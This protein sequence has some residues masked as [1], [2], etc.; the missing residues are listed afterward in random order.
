MKDCFSLCLRYES[1]V[2]K[3]QSGRGSLYA[4]MISFLFHVG[5]LF[6]RIEYK[7]YSPDHAF[8]DLSV[9]FIEIHISNKKSYSGCMFVTEILVRFLSTTIRASLLCCLPSF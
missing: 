6:L 9:A 8:L 5:Y 3:T 1:S 7:V 4:R 2:V